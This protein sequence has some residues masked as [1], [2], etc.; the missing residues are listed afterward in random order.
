[1]QE[2]PAEIRN[3]A[4]AQPDRVADLD[5]ALEGRL[6]GARP[7]EPTLELRTD[8]RARLES[9]GYLV[10]TSD[11]LASGELGVVGGLNP[12][13]YMH[14]ASAL[15]DAAALLADGWPDRA[16]DLLKPIRSGG[17]RAVRTMALA[18]LQSNRPEEALPGLE[19][20]R[21]EGQAAPA[22]LTFLGAA[23]V[24]TGRLEEARS[25]FQ[26]GR[27]LDPEAAGPMI[28]FA[29][30]AEREG[31]LAA[32]ER[33][34]EEAER[35]SE[36][37]AEPR[38]KRAVLMLRQGRTEEADA[39][40]ESIE[41]WSLVSPRTAS[42][43]AAVERQAGRPLRA[44]RVLRRAL[45]GNPR[46]RQLLVDYAVTL[47]AAGRVDAALKIW[48]RAHALAPDDAR[49]KNDLAWGLAVADQELDLALTLAGEAVESLSE[50]P[51][52]LDTLAT[53][54]LAR[55]E[56]GPALRIAD[57][58]LLAAPPPL[59]AHLLYV[60]AAALAELGRNGEA[61]ASLRELR[62]APVALESPWTE[63]AAALER[64]LGL[65]PAAG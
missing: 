59:R 25:T 31:D 51:S 28:G 9:L 24:A 6:S 50:D 36:Q 41:E 33:W 19:A 15:L 64:R 53:V 3:L 46:H 7:L 2:D 23:Y 47:E 61:A 30:L 16:V 17:S 38:V 29:A 58:A 20:L 5:G 34:V 8:D 42:T 22:D 11:Q 52:V 35:H 32:A 44:Q 1:V 60:R 21:D 45:R 65:A 48:R 62:G 56:P 27:D 39:L 55:S 63:R 40:L 10:P 26:A 12:A 57:Q 37:P 18:A 49:S 4:P 14:E 43:L 13:D 54:H